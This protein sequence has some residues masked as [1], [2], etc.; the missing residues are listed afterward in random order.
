VVSCVLMY[1]YA[2]A[3]RSLASKHRLRSKPDPEGEPSCFDL[4]QTELAERTVFENRIDIHD[5]SP[6]VTSEVRRGSQKASN[7]QSYA[8][9][10][11]SGPLHA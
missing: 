3:M 10:L 11:Q 6:D 2:M 9:F 4:W 8:A 1:H 7:S 5:T